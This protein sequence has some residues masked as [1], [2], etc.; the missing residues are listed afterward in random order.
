MEPVWNPECTKM[1]GR[2]DRSSDSLGPDQ[3]LSCSVRLKVFTERLTFKCGCCKS[4]KINETWRDDL[5][6]AA[7]AKMKIILQT[8]GLGVLYQFSGRYLPE[9]WT[10]GIVDKSVNIGHLPIVWDHSWYIT[11][12]TVT[13]MVRS[14]RGV[15]TSSAPIRCDGKTNK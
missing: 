15:A 9:L 12:Y 4:S 14:A 5:T 2:S 3:I 10:D 6:R 7:I 8:H 1:T 13:N 11:L